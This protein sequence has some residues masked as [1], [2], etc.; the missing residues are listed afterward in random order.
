MSEPEE[1]LS[2]LLDEIKQLR[3]V[4]E[5]QEQLLCG[6][7]IGRKPPDSAFDVLEKWRHRDV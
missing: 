6:Y 5:A 4:I 3:E 1:Q 7:R 2:E